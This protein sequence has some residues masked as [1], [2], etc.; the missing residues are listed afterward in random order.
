MQKS[1]AVDSA[2]GKSVS[3]QVFSIALPSLI[4]VRT[5]SGAF[6]TRGQD[7][8]I[9]NIEKRI[10]DWTFIPADMLL[11]ACVI[12][13]TD[14]REGLHVLHYKVGQKQSQHQDTVLM[15]PSDVEEGGETVFPN[16]KGITVLF[17]TGMSYLNVQKKGPRLSPNGCRSTIGLIH[18]M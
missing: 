14:H 7:K 15:Y 9:S 17:L 12:M 18:E 5:S 8:I 1:A 3:G 6:L 16:T 2:I 10:P 11:A 4:A 13:F